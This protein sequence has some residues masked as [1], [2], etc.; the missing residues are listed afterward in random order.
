M[1][2]VGRVKSGTLCC[3]TLRCG[4]FH[5]NLFSS[6][7]YSKPTLDSESSIYFLLT[8]RLAES[9]SKEEYSSLSFMFMKLSSI[10]GSWGRLVLL[11]FIKFLFCNVKSAAAMPFFSHLF[12]WA[13]SVFILFWNTRAVAICS[14]KPFMYSFND[15]FVG[16]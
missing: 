14:N 8:P 11:S 4:T 2:R 10:I 7:L 9:S 6:W 16:V 3:V 13:D 5:Q 15:F 1:R 12:A